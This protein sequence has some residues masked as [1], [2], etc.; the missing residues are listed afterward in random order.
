MAQR[1]AVDKLPPELRDELKDRLVSNGFSD[2]EG[3]A[4]WLESK[5]WKISKSALHRFGSDLEA[6]FNEATQ[7][8]RRSIELARAMRN[9]GSADDGGVLLDA[10]NSIVQDQL[11]RIALALRTVDTDP[12]E[13]VKLLS[14]VSRALADLGRLKVSYEKWQ[15]EVRVKAQAAADEVEAIGKKG[16]LSADALDTIRRGILGIA[17]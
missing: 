9:S 11:L 7:D 1:P 13:A 3:L 4:D 17:S 5:G 12:A 10:A 15:A 6:A 2:Y 16:G 14:Q 8:A